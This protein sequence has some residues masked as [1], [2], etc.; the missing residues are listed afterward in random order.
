MLKIHVIFPNRI[1]FNIIN[2]LLG[3]NKIHQEFNF[4]NIKA[5]KYMTST[6]ET[7]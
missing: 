1:N 4:L 6:Q 3:T 5:I 2:Y 7:P